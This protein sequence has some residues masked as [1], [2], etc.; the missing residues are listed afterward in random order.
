MQPEVIY[1]ETTNLCNANCIM[2]PHSKIKRNPI[3]MRD[4]IFYKAIEHL[5]EAAVKGKQIFLHKEGEPL[6]DPQI[7]ERIAYADRMLGQD[8]EIGINTNAMLLAGKK[9]KQ[10]LESG[11]DTVYFSVDGV[12]KK[13]YEAIRIN[14]NFET[15]VENIKHFFKLHQ[16]GK[17][18]VRVIMQMLIQNDDSNSA[19]AFKN[20]WKK[21]SCEFYIKKMHGYLDGGH[22]SQTLKRSRFQMNTCTDPNRIEV[23]FTDGNVGLCCWDYNN[24]YNIGNVMEDSLIILFNNERA[25]HL[26]RSLDRYEGEKIVPCNRCA[27]IFGSDE[28]SKY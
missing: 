10:L 21:Y 17:S 24:E 22:S 27:R 18:K 7:M 28:I 26:R 1:I 8:N 19:E 4:E 14:L 6:L 15:V 16:Q 12:S 3:I 23:V 2:C 5:K 11:I 25:N 9:A 20:I 13:E